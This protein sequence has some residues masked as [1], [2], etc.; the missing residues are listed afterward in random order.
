M[1]RMGSRMGRYAAHVVRVSA[2]ICDPATIFQSPACYGVGTVEYICDQIGWG[3]F[4]M[5]FLY[6]DI[7]L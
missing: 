4:R 3:G 5:D 6:H 7:F 1:G 2:V